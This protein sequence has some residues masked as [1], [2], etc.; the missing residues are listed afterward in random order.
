MNT[1]EPPYTSLHSSHPDR[2]GLPAQPGGFTSGSVLSHPG[3]LTISVPNSPFIDKAQSCELL[4]TKPHTDQAALG[5]RDHPMQGQDAL[6]GKHS[7]CSKS[8]TVPKNHYLPKCREKK[9]TKF[10]PVPY[11]KTFM[12]FHFKLAST[13]TLQ[14]EKT[15]SRTSLQFDGP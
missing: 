13:T 8:R 10:H 9:P 1:N 14:R 2:L 15:L 3:L 11:C 7:L 5:Q 4:G 12:Q 6:L